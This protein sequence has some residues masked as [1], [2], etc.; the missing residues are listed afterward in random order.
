MKFCNRNVIQR[1]ELLEL[2]SK[3]HMVMKHQNHL[4]HQCKKKL[5][6]TEI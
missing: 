5:G 3:H 4:N 6:N 1:F 2:Y